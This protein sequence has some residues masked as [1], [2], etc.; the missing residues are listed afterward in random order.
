MNNAMIS[1]EELN[2]ETPILSAHLNPDSVSVIIDTAGED[3]D[4]DKS[5]TRVRFF[6]F[7]DEYRQLV[8][9]LVEYVMANRDDVIV[10]NNGYGK[11]IYTAA[12]LLPV[13]ALQDFAADII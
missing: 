3:F 12:K 7:E 1:V 9:F 2:T 13:E 8:G 4:T 10:V 6:E 5:V 11:S